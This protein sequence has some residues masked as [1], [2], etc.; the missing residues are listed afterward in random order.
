MTS[1]MSFCTEML[2]YTYPTVYLVHLIM[3]NLIVNQLLLF[4]L[5]KYEITIFLVMM[6]MDEHVLTQMNVHLDLRVALKLPNV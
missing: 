4:I 1:S 3:T 2:A 6:E 5:D